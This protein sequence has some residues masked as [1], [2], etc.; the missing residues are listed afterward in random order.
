MVS[1][2]AYNKLK[3]HLNILLKKH[4]AFKDMV[5]N[6]GENFLVGQLSNPQIIDNKTTK[7]KTVNINEYDMV[8]SIESIFKKEPSDLINT[9]IKKIVCEN[10]FLDFLFIKKEAYTKHFLGL[11][12]VNEGGHS[13][14]ECSRLLANL[15]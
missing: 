5:I 6:S 1:I 3:A 11:R 2:Q 9:D 8:Q 15:V 10:Y 12:S 4:Q 13:N 14:Q 7:N